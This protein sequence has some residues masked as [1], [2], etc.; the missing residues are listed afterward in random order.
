VSGENEGMIKLTGL[1]SGKTK[2]GSTYYS[3]YL[4]AAKILIFK[5][6]YKRD[7]KDPDVIAYVARHVKKQNFNENQSVENNSLDDLPF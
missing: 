5:N 1:W 4:G 7:D 6:K 2:D 3:G